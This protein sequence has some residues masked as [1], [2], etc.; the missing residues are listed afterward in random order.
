MG[1]Q[2]CIE[3]PAHTRIALQPLGDAPAVLVVGLHAHVQR[4]GAAQHQ[5]AVHGP[6]DRACRLLQKA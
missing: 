3:D 4:L 6:R 2:A 5:Q 1:R